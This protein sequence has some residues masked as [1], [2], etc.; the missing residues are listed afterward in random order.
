MANRIPQDKIDEMYDAFIEEQSI[1]HVM[2][3]CKVSKNAARKYVNEGDP[4]RDIPSF[5]ERYK[6]V[7]VKNQKKSE[8]KSEIYFRENLALVRKFKGLVAKLLTQIEEFDIAHASPWK[9]QQVL[10]GIFKMEAFLHGQATEIT[11]HQHNHV[12][13]TKLDVSRETLSK[14]A[15]LVLEDKREKS[16]RLAIRNRLKEQNEKALEEGRYEDII[17]VVDAE[18]EEA[19]EVTTVD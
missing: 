1:Q 11:H 6:A 9:L 13:T 17:Q 5:K 14:I 18:F 15:R 16:D 10:D 7:S 12:H 8:D 2:T 3:K 4:K 19:P